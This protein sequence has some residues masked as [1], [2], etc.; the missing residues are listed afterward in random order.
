[1]NREAVELFV[2]ELE[3]TDLPQATGR[4]CRESQ[5]NGT[6]SY[7]ALGIGV[8]VAARE[9]NVSP[10]VRDQWLDPDNPDGGTDWPEEVAGYYGLGSTDPRIVLPEPL[11][12]VK[13]STSGAND[14]LRHDFWTIA[15]AYRQTYLKDEG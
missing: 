13:A 1:M 14:N 11:G 7:C 9:L 8:L 3:S 10:E 6:R 2:N 15:Q 4:L 12:N 5:F